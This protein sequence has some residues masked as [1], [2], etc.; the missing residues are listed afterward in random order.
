[1]DADWASLF[2]AVRTIATATA[3]LATGATLAT[4]TA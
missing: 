4:T 1:M 3:A 2:L